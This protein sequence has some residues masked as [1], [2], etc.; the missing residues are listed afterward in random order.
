MSRPANRSRKDRIK[1]R[2]TYKY[3]CLV[4]FKARE[5]RMYSRDEPRRQCRVPVSSSCFCTVGD[6]VIVLQ[7]LKS[8]FHLRCLHR[9]LGTKWNNK[10]T[11]TMQV[12]VSSGLSTMYMLLRQRSLGFGLAIWAGG[13]YSGWQ[14]CWSTWQQSSISER[15]ET[16]P[17]FPSPLPVQKMLTWI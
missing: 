7:T 12:L 13:S 16:I 1:T 5:P 9:F 17:P 8:G 4:E 10:V 6:L 3:S 2:P 15:V 14:K 11:I